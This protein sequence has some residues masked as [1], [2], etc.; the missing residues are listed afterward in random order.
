MPKKIIILRHGEKHDAYQLCST[1]VERSLALEAQYLGKN[2]TNA[3]ELFKHGEVPA[4]FFAITLHT[5]ELAS[6]SA[7][8]WNLPLIAYSA[9]PAGS[10]PWSDSD[11][12]LDAR[13][14]QAAADVLSSA[15]DDKVVVMVWEH[16]HIADKKLNKQK[17]TLY[18]LLGLDTLGSDVPDKWEG[19]NYDF[20]WVVDYDGKSPTKFR[21]VLQTYTAPYADLPQ[22]A[23]GVAATLPS[24]C[25]S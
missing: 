15:W 18:S 8:S 16:K 22:N 13:T 2:A 19:A 10:S 24:D 7:Q 12:V 11:A 6:P 3:G 5:I 4:A 1:G 14:V 9:V 17:V 23:W 25:Q 21:S 20:F